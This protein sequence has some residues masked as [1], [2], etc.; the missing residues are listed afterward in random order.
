MSKEIAEIIELLTRLIGTPSI[1]GQEDKSATLILDF[2]ASHSIRADRKGNNVVV[3]NKYYNKEKQTLLLNSHHDTVKPVS[4]WKRNPYQAAIEDEKLYGLGSNDAGGCVA[5]LT[6]VFLHFYERPDL[7]MNLLLVISSEEEISGANGIVSVLPD[8]SEISCGIVGEPTGMEMAIA[9]RGLMV[10]DCISFGKAGHAARDEGEN[11]IYKAME[12]IEWF[13]TYQFP[14]ISPLLGPVKMA[15]TMVNAGTQHNMVPDECHFTVDIRSTEA[16]SNEEIF[17][18][19]RS[20]VNCEVTPRSLRLKPSGIA[21]DH[22]LVIAGKA[23]GLQM[24]G[25]PTLSD[26]ALMPFPTV[27]IG[28]GI[29]SRSHTA[30]EFIELDEIS[31]GFKIYDQLLSLL[32]L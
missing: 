26:Q 17:E 24:I 22:P 30:D 5:T 28:P 1:S 25:S 23:A 21:L 31:A 11:A 3:R 19:I 27:K 18:Q 8:F 9:E 10:L 6:G 2:F 12:T 32:L 4:S 7:K 14:R 20:M 13:R 15:V 29:S 16:Y